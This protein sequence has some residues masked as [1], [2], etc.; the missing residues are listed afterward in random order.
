LPSASRSARIAGD[1]PPALRNPFCFGLASAL[2][3]RRLDAEL[4]LALVPLRCR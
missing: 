4:L 3:S 2:V 1:R